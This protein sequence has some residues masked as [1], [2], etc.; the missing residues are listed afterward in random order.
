MSKLDSERVVTMAF[1]RKTVLL[2]LL[3]LTI[4]SIVI[5]YPLVD[6]ERQQTDSYFIHTLSDSIATNGYA[7]WVFHPL[8]LFGYYP[9][10]YPSGTP[11][12]IA[13]L[14]ELTGLGIEV[15]MLV[16]DMAIAS[17]FCL[18]VFGLSRLFI[19][20]SEYV[21]LAVLLAILGSRFVDTTYWDGSARGLFVVM[22]TLVVFTSFLFASTRR[23]ALLLLVFAYA[24]GC[25][26][27]HHMAVLL[28]MFALAYLIAAFQIHFVVPKLRNEKR[29]MIVAYNIS[30]A[31]LVIILSFI[32]Y[33]SFRDFTT[34]LFGDDPLFAF[35]P[36]FIA[37]LLNIAASYTNQIGFV[38]PV[39]ILGIP[40]LLGRHRPS[41]EVLFPVA[42]LIAA[43]PIIAHSLYLSMIIAPFAA[44]LGAMWLLKLRADSP[45]RRRLKIAI[46]AALVVSSLILPVW[47]TQRWNQEA[48]LSGDTVEVDSQPFNDAAY[49]TYVW[50]GLPVISNVNTVTEQLSALSDASFLGPGM[51]IPLSG[52]VSAAD[53]QGNITMSSASFPANLYKWFEYENEPLVGVYLRGLMTRGL[54]YV[55]GLGQPNE[56]TEYLLSH[57]TMWVAIASSQ[58]TKFID[59]YSVQD[60]EFSSQLR[61]STWYPEG[62]DAGQGVSL[63]SYLT[64][65]SEGIAL[66]LFRYPM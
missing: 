10:S 19:K 3:S 5:R 35:E 42:V 28:V 60:A 62:L 23:P 55:Y 8:S 56:A 61:S 11:F 32:T 54:D 7:R 30:L 38:L 22:C 2:L 41:M 31:L 43:V 37:A 18:A 21:M 1:S 16:Y 58:S 17:F 65:E 64:Y 46:I 36:E 15:S 24:L 66:F 44:I 13:E 51:F 4:L 33:P 53:V 59:A 48:Y 25:F 14:S 52:D 50:Q 6:H 12:L 63:D 49:V 34:Q 9:L 57:D 29:G 26:F 47:S 40:S 20:R 45:R 39:A 27:V